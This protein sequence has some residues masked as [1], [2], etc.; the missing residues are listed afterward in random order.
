ML[1]AL[2]VSGGERTGQMSRHHLQGPLSGL[3]IDYSLYLPAGYHRDSTR[4]GV[5]FFLHGLSGES[6]LKAM[7]TALEAAVEQ[8]L[9][10]PMIIVHPDGFGGSWWGERLDSTVLAETNIIKELLPHIDRAYRTDTTARLIGGLSMGGYGSLSYALRYPQLFKACISIDGPLLREPSRFTGSFATM[11]GDD[12][13]R[14]ERY[15]PFYSARALVNSAQAAPSLLLVSGEFVKENRA[16]GAWLDSL[17]IPQKQVHLHET[18]C[19]HTFAC[20]MEAAAGVMF[21]FVG[22]QLSAADS[23]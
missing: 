6:R 23:R 22:Q 1:L 16:F 11:F 5:W 12:A 2:G 21:A 20:L 13:L 17:G 14:F 15:N 10:R 9:C 18:G 4:Y 8:G 7:A 19:T 3:R